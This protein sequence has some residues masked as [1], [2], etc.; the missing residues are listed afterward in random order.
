MKLEQFAMAGS[1]KIL[2]GTYPRDEEE[3]KVIKYNNLL[4]RTKNVIL[5]LTRF[6]FP[7]PPTINLFIY[8]LIY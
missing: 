4:A 6:N 1:N 3:S 7:P 8:L 5:R 2:S